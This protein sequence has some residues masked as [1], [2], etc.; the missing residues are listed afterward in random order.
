MKMVIVKYLIS[1]KVAT[2]STH[3]A[4]DVH[5]CVEQHEYIAYPTCYAKLTDFFIQ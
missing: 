4:I 3:A 2:L 5:T 1:Q